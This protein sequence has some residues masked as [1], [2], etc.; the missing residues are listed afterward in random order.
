VLQAIAT[1]GADLR[2]ARAVVALPSGDGALAVEGEIVRVDTFPPD[3]L[4]GLQLADS[5]THDALWF[6]VR[7]DGGTYRVAWRTT[8]AGVHG[9]VTDLATY[10]AINLSLR[11]RVLRDPAGGG[12]YEL[13]YSI[14]DAAY[15]STVIAGAVDVPTLA[16]F[17]VDGTDSAIGSGLAAYFDEFLTH[18]PEGKN[19]LHWYAYRDPLLPGSA[20]M[21]GARITVQKM[22]PAHTVAA[23]VSRLIVICDDAETVCDREP[24]GG[25]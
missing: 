7:N 1:V 25:L 17:A 9:A 4:I 12:G 8:I 23:A 22:K 2:G 15:V 21:Q 20:D 5:V 18:A 13:Q 19:T 24:I 10:D 16:G 11:L 14:S 6:G 3:V